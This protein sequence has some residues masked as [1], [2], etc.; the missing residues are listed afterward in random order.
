MTYAKLLQ[1]LKK[2]DYAPVYFLQGE[3]TYYIDR[4]VAHIEDKV[5]PE[6]ARG[7]DMTTFYGSDT[8][9][10][11]VITQAK[12]FP[13]MAPYQVVIVKEAQNMQDLHKEAG[14]KV[15]LNYLEAPNPQT[16]LLF[17][18]KHKSL[19]QRKTFTKKIAQK[20]ILFTSKKMYEKALP[21]WIQEH[22]SEKGYQ[23]T[24]EAIHMILT[25]VGDNLQLLSNELD[26]ITTN[27]S[28]EVP[29]THSIVREQVSKSKSYDIFDLQQAIQRYEV[30]RVWEITHHFSKNPK[31]YPLLPQI[32]LLTNFFSK[33]LILHG[34]PRIMPSQIASKLGIPSYFAKSYQEALAHY[35]LS[36][37]VANI[38]HLHQADLQIKGVGS[39]S[40]PEPVIL[41]TLVAKLMAR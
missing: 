33:L 8:N 10:T 34:Y 38:E 37:T 24:P 13:M 14:Q 7:F 26:K 35:S 27:I 32:T 5:V 3:E 31:K 23:I 2:K 6:G 39:P 25:L 30:Q 41:K 20:A 40:M 15:L 11:H 21:Q 17:V 4:V 9:L 22:V 18:Y 19:D 1:S 16:L 28:P 29:I 12:R 36:Q